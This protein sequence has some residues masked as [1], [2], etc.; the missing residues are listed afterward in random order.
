[1][2]TPPYFFRLITHH[3]YPPPPPAITIC[4][5]LPANDVFALT[6]WRASLWAAVLCPER[7]WLSGVYL[8]LPTQKHG[9]LLL[10]LFRDSEPGGTNA[11]RVEDIGKHQERKRKQREVQMLPEALPRWRG[12]WTSVSTEFSNNY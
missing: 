7:N 6:Y 8:L 5:S 9:S 2:R 12:R 10:N 1:M 3:F 4:S 11:G